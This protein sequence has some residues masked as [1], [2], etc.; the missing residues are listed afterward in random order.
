MTD[1]RELEALCERCKKSPALELHECPFRADVHNDPR[2][3]CTCCMD[4]QSECAADI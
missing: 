4:C 1:T 2:P 3:C